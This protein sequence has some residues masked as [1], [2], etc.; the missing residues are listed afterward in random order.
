MT[1]AITSTVFISKAILVFF[2]F[3]STVSTEREPL[4]FTW[5]L[6]N[7]PLELTLKVCFGQLRLRNLNEYLTCCTLFC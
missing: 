5:L 2:L 7:H 6:T 3:F 4:S 1:F